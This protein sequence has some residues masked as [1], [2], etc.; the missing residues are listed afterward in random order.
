MRTESPGKT[1]VMNMTDFVQMEAC[2]KAFKEGLEKAREKGGNE[3]R[4]EI[5]RSLLAGTDMSV[6][7]IAVVFEIPLEQ[8]KEL[9]RTVR[10][11]LTKGES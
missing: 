5:A 6:E 10:G 8:V 2:E 11:H 3:A 4:E 9:S 7:R 1:I